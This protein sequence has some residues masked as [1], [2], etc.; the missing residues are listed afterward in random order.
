RVRAIVLT[1]AGRTFIAGADI[2]EF[3]D[4]SGTL[5]TTDPDPNELIQAIEDAAKP[6]VAAMFGSARSTTA[7]V[8]RA[9]LCACSSSAGRAGESGDST[10]GPR[11]L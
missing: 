8:S 11:A 2:G 10:V 9:I 3:A 7:P 4:R 1:C 6:V 5:M